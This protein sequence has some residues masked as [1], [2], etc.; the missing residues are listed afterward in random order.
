[1]SVYKSYALIT[2]ALATI[3]THA[4]GADP[5]LPYYA[6]QTFIPGT[7]IDNP[8]FPMPLNRTFEYYGEF[9]ED[10]EIQSEG[11]TLSNIGPGRI[12]RKS[13]V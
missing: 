6:T 4:A 7:A 8:Y 5:L 10:G 12:D 3:V 2:A 1:M 11:F 9:E 13:V